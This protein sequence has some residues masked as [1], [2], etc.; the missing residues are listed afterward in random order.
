MLYGVPIIVMPLKA[1]MLVMPFGVLI[2]DITKLAITLSV[3]PLN[4]SCK[5]K[6]IN[7]VC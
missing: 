1:L 5:Y 6:Y 3:L 2:L 7:V 4:D